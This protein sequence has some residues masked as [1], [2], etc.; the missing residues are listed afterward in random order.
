MLQYEHPTYKQ[1][2]PLNPS[3]LKSTI[4]LDILK[5]TTPPGDLSISLAAPPNWTF[6]PGDTIIGNIVRKTHLV[7]PD[8]SLK[9]S[10]RGQTVTKF[11]ES[12]GDSKREY[13]AT[14]NLWPVTWDKAFRGPLH[15]PEG[16][17]V[18]KYLT[19]PFEVTIPRRPSASAIKRHVAAESYLSLDDGSVARHTLPG[20]FSCSRYLGSDTE[21]R[22]SIEYYL[23][24]VL[25][26]T[27]GGSFVN[28]RAT[29][30]VVIRHTPSE[31]PLLYYAT[32]SWL[33][34][35]LTVQSQR[36]EPGREDARLSFRQKTQK[37]FGSSRVPKFT[38]RL[39][40]CVPTA[41]QLDNPLPIPFTVKVV[42]ELGPNKTSESIR[43]TL[44]SVQIQIHSL[45]LTITAKTDLRAPGTFNAS[46]AHF[47]Q[48]TAHHIALLTCNPPLLLPGS[49][50]PDEG[51][52]EPIDI[53]KLFEISLRTDGLQ[54]TGRRRPLWRTIFNDRSVYPDF[55]SYLIKHG[56]WICWEIGLGV[57]GE[58]MKV[59]GRA[60]VRVLAAD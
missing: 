4:M 51:Q 40:V 9:L 12:R 1:T 48:N 43:G 41:V 37:F 8:A 28:C 24:A 58:R 59:K 25:Q 50:G 39:E 56:H 19:C 52:T 17:D 27:R 29:C 53:G 10:L 60:G 21:C 13:G 32:K 33:S 22:G 36:L 54:W 3:T 35:S 11:E 31:P 5:T 30:R 6:A 49:V 14:W 44:Q 46:K 42:P 18:D 34:T 45:K 15:I 26:Y 57:A 47:D 16:A 38:Y 20:S 23:E 2:Q 55:V 7:T